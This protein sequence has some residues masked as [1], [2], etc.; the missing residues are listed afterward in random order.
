VLVQPIKQGKFIPL[1]TIVM[2]TDWPENHRFRN[3]QSRT[4]AEAVKLFKAMLQFEMECACR[5]YDMH[6][7]VRVVR[8]FIQLGDWKNKLE[9]IKILENRISEDLKQY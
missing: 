3:H 8:D 2:R 9:N 5:A 1:T 7:V 6:P 4:E